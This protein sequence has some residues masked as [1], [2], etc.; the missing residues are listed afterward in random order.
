MPR[1][2]REDLQTRLEGLRERAHLDLAFAMES[3]RETMNETDS[4]WSLLLGEE[5][6]ASRLKSL[7]GKAT[8]QAT[9]RQLPL[10]RALE[11]SA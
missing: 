1:I 6:P 2:S 5:P 11:E 9:S 10:A 3:Y 7:T 4:L 8:T